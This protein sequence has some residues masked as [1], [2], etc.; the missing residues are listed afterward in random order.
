M[1]P[2]LRMIC[3]YNAMG[4][5]S[6][7]GRKLQKILVVVVCL[8][9]LPHLHYIFL[10]VT[11]LDC[12]F[13][14]RFA[15]FHFY[16]VNAA[17]WSCFYSTPAALPIFLLFT[18]F[19]PISVAVAPAHCYVS[20][21]FYSKGID[22]IVEFLSVWQCNVSAVIKVTTNLYYWILQ[23]GYCYCACCIVSAFKIFG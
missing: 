22:F 23:L 9:L 7:I 14:L 16:L 13:Q 19:L 18:I 10:K 4:N 11:H 21:I 12:L 3:C 6:V 5:N 8:F 1:L 15:T 2:F 20:G 17:S